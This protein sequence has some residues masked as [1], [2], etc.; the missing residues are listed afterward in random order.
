MRSGTVGRLPDGVKIGAMHEKVISL[1]TPVFFL[2]IAL[3]LLVGR[4]RG[5]AVMR[6]NDAVTSIGLGVMSQVAGVFTRVLRIGIYVWL[7]EHLAL[8][9]WPTDAL[10][11]F[12]L[13]LVFYDFCYYWHH[14]FMHRVAAAWAAHVVHHSSED[15]NLSTALRQTGS[16]AV[17]GWI[18]YVP[19]A[20]AGVPPT[21]F[22]VA[23]LIDLLYQFWIHTEQVGR[24]GWFDR[25][26][27]SPSNHRVHHAVNDRYLDRNYGGILIVWDR[28]FGTFQDERADEPPVY[29]TRHPLRSFNP[30]WANLEVYAGLARSSLSLP[31]WRDRLQVWWRP[32]GWQPG[33]MP[34]PPRDAAGDARRFF[35]RQPGADRYDPI[36]S[37]AITRYVVP[38]F[39]AVLAIAVHFLEFQRS[40]ALIPLLAYALWIVLA[41]TALGGLLE[42]R[43]TF[44][45]LEV[46]RHAVAVLALATAGTVGLPGPAPGWTALLL[47]WSLGSLLH[48]AWLARSAPSVVAATPP[49][50][51]PQ[52]PVDRSPAKD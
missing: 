23:A 33:G 32:P 17:L 8:A 41:L 44:A 2:L 7:Y 36:R 19:M 28:L 35:A 47:C 43:P 13:A 5:K 20:I 45:W 29:G 31:R 42:G 46:T 26:F 40:A 51:F 6:L 18:P 24:L 9:R 52:M 21:V 50:G 25:V 37:K 27:A 1:A 10:W 14:R 12:V 39:A 48:A 11:S 34:T 15:Y 49:L 3:E 16:G 4:A 38:Q 22:A 30:V